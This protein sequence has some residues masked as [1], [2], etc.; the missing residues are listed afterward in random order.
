VG[1]GAVDNKSSSTIRSEITATDLTGKVRIGTIQKGNGKTIFD[2][3]NDIIKV[4]NDKIKIGTAALPD[5]SDGFFCRTG[6]FQIGDTSA[7]KY[8]KYTGSNFEI[9]ANLLVGKD[10]NSIHFMDSDIKITD[11]GN[12]AGTTW[13]EFEDNRYNNRRFEFVFTQNTDN[14]SAQQ[15]VLYTSHTAT[16]GYNAVEIKNVINPDSSGASF[17]ALGCKRPTD[18]FP[19]FVN[20]LSIKT[21]GNNVYLNINRGMRFENDTLG[22]Q[23][24]GTLMTDSNGNLRFKRNGIWTT[25]LLQ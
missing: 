10:K 16:Y 6:S 15:F 23:P 18:S 5:G 8:I 12:S 19:S 9:M 14:S 1:L 2:L 17:L 13:V 20:L 24:N 21:V 11:R 3:D 7:A 25:V 4:D 22:D